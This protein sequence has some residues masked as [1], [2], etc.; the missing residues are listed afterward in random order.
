VQVGAGVLAAPFPVKPKVVEALVA[1]VRFQ[2]ALRTV[3][4]DPPGVYVPFHRL[5]MLC[6]VASGHD[7]VQP[8]SADVP[9]LVT[10][11]SAWKP[12]DQEPVWA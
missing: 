8:L 6:P 12:P 10:L 3:A 9:V 5:L 2:F 4:T 1:T 11:T 7:T